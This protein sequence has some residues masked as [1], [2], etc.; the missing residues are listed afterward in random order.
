M[1]FSKFATKHPERLLKDVR[2]VKN[3]TGNIFTIEV[4]TDIG[5]YKTL[6]YEA[7][8]KKDASQIVAKLNYLK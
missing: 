6:E 1:F 4:R 3:K 2:E 8:D 5:K 7:K